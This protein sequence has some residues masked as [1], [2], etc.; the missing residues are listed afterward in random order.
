MSA[1]ANLSLTKADWETQR[2]TIED[3]YC[4][5]EKNLGNLMKFMEENY[6]FEAR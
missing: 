4:K 2:E 1:G 6:Q 5:Q 3:L